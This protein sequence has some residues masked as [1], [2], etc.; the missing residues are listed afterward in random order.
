MESFGPIANLEYCLCISDICRLKKNPLN[1]DNSG[2]GFCEFCDARAA[3]EARKMNKKKVIDGR[4]IRIDNPDG[5]KKGNTSSVLV[6][7]CC[8]IVAKSELLLLLDP[9]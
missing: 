8:S 3:R 9:G 1:G 7:L 4:Q 2:I 5:G 6:L